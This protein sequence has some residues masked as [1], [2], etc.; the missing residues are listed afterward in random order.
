MVRFYRYFFGYLK[1][2][3]YGEFCE[4]ILSVFAQNGI[5]LWNS[6]FSHEAIE[7]Y[8]SIKDFKRIRSVA[9]GKKVRIH[10]LE[11][12]GLPFILKRYEKRFGIPAG[13]VIFFAILKIMSCYIWVIDIEGNHRLSH[14]EI[15]NAC[16]EIGITEGVKNDSFFPKIAREKLMLKTDGI[17]W[18]SLNVEG[19]RLTVNL[20]ETKEKEKNENFCNLKASS[21]GIIEKINVT[22]GNCLVKVGDTVKKGDILVS[23]IVEMQN[24]TKFVNSAGT[25]TAEVIKDFE[26]A[27]NFKKTITVPTGKVKTKTA[28]DFFGLKIPLYLKNE[29]GEYKS[30]RSKFTLELFGNKLPIAIYRKTFEFYEKRNA[31]Y[32][33]D[34]LRSILKKRFEKEFKNK[35]EGEFKVLKEEFSVSDV[36]I[37]LKVKAQIKENIAKEDILLISAGN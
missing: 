14:A 18:A 9:K 11:R 34:E 5:M 26:T 3:I 1:V 27:E 17:A 25:V 29:N 15:L 21:D 2:K 32:R 6:V 30:C 12:H 31:V 20:T 4:K 37:T 10:I 28:I 23:G 19:S 7:S 24:E 33:E 36:G 8:I 35:A 22:S 16:K 13:A